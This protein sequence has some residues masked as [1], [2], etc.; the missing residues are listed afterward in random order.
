LVGF[1]Q[2]RSVRDVDRLLDLPDFE[3]EIERPFV[4][5]VQF[6]VFVDGALATSPVLMFLTVT[7]ALR[8]AAPPASVTLPVSVA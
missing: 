8:T 4:V 5:D 3:R 7:L 1:E 2:R 6:E